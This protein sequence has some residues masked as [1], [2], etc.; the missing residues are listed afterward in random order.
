MLAWPL[1]NPAH[2]PLSH[3]SVDAE[4]TPKSETLPEVTSQDET[5]MTLKSIYVYPL[6]GQF[7]YNTPAIQGSFWACTKVLHLQCAY[8]IN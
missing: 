8:A 2:L 3:P 1:L 4:P 6:N 7:T 5:C